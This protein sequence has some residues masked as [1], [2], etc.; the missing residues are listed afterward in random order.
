MKID[1]A[2]AR[3]AS[4]NHRT[5]ENALLSVGRIHDGT[6]RIATIDPMT[7]ERIAAMWLDRDQIRT[8]VG[9]LSNI[10]RIT[11]LT[12]QESD[13]ADARDEDLN[14]GAR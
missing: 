7:G 12:K 10:A 13:D 6:I 3:D 11:Q 4:G 2:K 14:R 9:Y 8:L 1:Q 5:T